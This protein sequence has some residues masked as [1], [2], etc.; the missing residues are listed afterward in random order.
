M[1]KVSPKEK[2][3]KLRMVQQKRL[4]HG[5]PNLKYWL[6]GIVGVAAIVGIVVAL[7]YFGESKSNQDL[8][9]VETGDS[10]T[11]HYRLWIDENK[12]GEIE[13]AKPPYQERENITLDV[14]SVYHEGV[15]QGKSQLIHGFY[16]NILGKTINIPFSFELPN[17][18]D[19]DQNG[20]DDI[21]GG[22]VLGYTKGELANTKLKYWI[23]IHKIEK[24][25][26]ESTGLRIS[27]IN[28][29][30]LG[31]LFALM[32]FDKKKGLTLF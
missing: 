1:P 29:N 21:S 22:V 32:Y 12:D 24:G 20:L 14:Y 23:M 4:D 18:I 10:V 15:P 7:Y 26:D 27:S 6:M 17:N 9:K 2:A 3:R 19:E 8:T 31:Y 30:P 28:N 13:Y 16:L 25:K 5:T 11:M